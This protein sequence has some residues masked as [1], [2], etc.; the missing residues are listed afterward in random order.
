MV[1]CESKIGHPKKYVLKEI[2][3]CG[4]NLLSACFLHAL[5]RIMGGGRVGFNNL[6]NL[7]LNNEHGIHTSS[8]KYEGSDYGHD[9]DLLIILHWLRISYTTRSEYKR[10]SKSPFKTHLVKYSINSI[11]DI[12]E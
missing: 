11:L 6:K 2:G 12:L 9:V 8:K 7:H 5:V 1:A 10:R 3:V 4:S